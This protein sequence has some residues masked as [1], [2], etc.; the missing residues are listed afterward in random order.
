MR[1]K[2][3]TPLR[4]TEEIAAVKEAFNEAIEVIVKEYMSRMVE[5]LLRDYPGL[6]FRG[7]KHKGHGGWPLYQYRDKN[8]SDCGTRS[9]GIGQ[10]LCN[11]SEDKQRNIFKQISFIS[12]VWN[13]TNEITDGRYNLYVSL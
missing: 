1:T 11:M 9:N 2:T 13:H 12:N 8:D 3:L 6:I 4:Y 10:K 5:A 7:I